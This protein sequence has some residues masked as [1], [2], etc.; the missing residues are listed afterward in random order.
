[1][2]EMITGQK[3]I[4]IESVY[5]TI[6]FQASAKPIKMPAAVD[7][8]IFGPIIRRAVAKALPDRFATAEEM[9]RAIYDVVGETYKP[10]VP[11]REAVRAYARTGEFIADGSTETDMTVPRSSGMPSLEDIERELGP[12]DPEFE[13]DNT[14][15]SANMM[16]SDTVQARRPRQDSNP[17]ANTGVGRE[18]RRDSSPQRAVQHTPETSRNPF[19]ESVD[20]E[21]EMSHL[22]TEEP[23]AGFPWRDVMMG[24]LF[25]GVLL[26]ALILWEMNS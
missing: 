16:P 25:G 15:D 26:A 24:V 17:R 1:M 5:D 6:L 18:V 12:L 2:A 19:T 13:P 4:T 20:L 14:T 21:S 8:H 9:A 11:Q 22:Y 23:A 7:E 10:L 3:I